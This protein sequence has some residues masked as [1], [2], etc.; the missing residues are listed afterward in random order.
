MCDCYR[1][2]VLAVHSFDLR[3]DL[4]CERFHKGA[5]EAITGPGAVMR[6]PDAIIRHREA[7]IRARGLEFDDNFRVCPIRRE[8]VFQGVDD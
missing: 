7:P 2:S 8:A 5:T 1:E 3:L 6:P 4:L